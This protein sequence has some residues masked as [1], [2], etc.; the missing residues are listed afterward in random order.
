MT[1]NK[2]ATLFH[3]IARIFDPKKARAS[4]EAPR[5]TVETAQDLFRKADF[6]SFADS[7]VDDDGVPMVFGALLFVGVQQFDAVH[8]SVGRD[9]HIQFIADADGFH[10]DLFLVQPDVG[11]V[12]TRVVGGF[13]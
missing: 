2:D 4:E 10:L 8:R 9:V 13:Y 7:L 3:S 11:D 6:P 1:G 5:P 12:V